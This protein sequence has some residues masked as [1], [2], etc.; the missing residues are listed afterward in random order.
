MTRN[1]A[2]PI[3]PLRASED[4]LICNVFL[5][6]LDGISFQQEDEIRP[7]KG[8]IDR[9]SPYDAKNDKPLCTWIVR[10]SARRFL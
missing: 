9:P 1:R 10:P 6:P 3:F 2:H 7:T 5:V 8:I 4:S